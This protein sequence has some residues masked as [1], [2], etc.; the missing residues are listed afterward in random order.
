MTGDRQ[1]MRKGWRPLVALAASYLLVLQVLLSGLTMIGHPASAAA[2]GLAAVI[3]TSDGIQAAP[4]HPDAP[5]EPHGLTCCL[6][7]CSG[8]GPAVAPPAAAVAVLFAAPAPASIR[9]VA[10]ERPGD[11]ERYSPGRARAPPPTA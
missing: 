8:A 3:C 2:D 7:G 9:V 10:T 5:V 1:V 11:G 6:I 4:G